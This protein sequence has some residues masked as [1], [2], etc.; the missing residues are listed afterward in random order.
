MRCF[1]AIDI[2]PTVKEELAELQTELAGAVDIRKGD[3]KWVRPEAMHLTLKFL[4]EITD[5]QVVD[6]C[7]AVEQVV[8][9]AAPFEIDVATVGSFGGKSARVLWVGAGAE[10]AALAKLHADLEA[11]LAQ[12]GFPPE[13]RKFSA[14]LTLCRIRNRHAGFKLGRLTGDYADYSVGRIPVEAISIYQSQLTPAGP[15]YTL[16]G[17]Y[18]LHSG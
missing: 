17:G 3:V 1:I 15:V 18:P 8:A 6:V 14:H 11:Q 13:S 4:G 5:Q 2:D 12:V 7:S 9:G 10:S 16:L